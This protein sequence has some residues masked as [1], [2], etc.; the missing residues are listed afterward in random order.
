MN[1]VVVAA[2]QRVVSAT[3]TKGTTFGLTNGYVAPGDEITLP[4]GRFRVTA[5]DV[6]GW[7]A[8]NDHSHT[9]DITLTAEPNGTAVTCP[10]P[11][12]LT[13]IRTT[14]LALTNAQVVVGTA[15]V[16]N[17]TL[18]AQQRAYP[19]EIAGLWE[20]PGGQVEPN[21]SD[22][23]AVARECQEE[24]GVEVKVGETIGPD[25]ALPKGKLLR[26]YQA[27]LADPKATPHPHDHA[28]LRWLTADQ[29]NSVEWL[30][31]DRV[32]LPTLKQA[33]QQTPQP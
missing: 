7:S 32:L 19:P 22:K 13:Q 16:R 21:E 3:L 4:E 6:D 33:L 15:M 25:V 28:A 8:V 23:D 20:L 27:T 24:L 18:L 10:L 17:G 26:I 12:L 5:V 11:W 1:E 30:P 29:L 14:A 2:P 9:I 31:A